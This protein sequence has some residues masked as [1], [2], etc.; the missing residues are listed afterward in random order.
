LGCFFD[1]LG[2]DQQY[3]LLRDWV[4]HYVEDEA[5]DRLMPKA[6]VVQRLQ[7]MGFADFRVV[8]GKHMDVVPVARKPE[9]NGGRLG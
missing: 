3:D 4:L 7:R 5:S 8:Y 1:F 9:E 2:G 6:D